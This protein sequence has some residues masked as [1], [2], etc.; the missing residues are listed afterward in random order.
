[1][2][3]SLHCCWVAGRASA[4]YKT[5]CWY[6]D[7][8]RGDPT[9]TRHKWFAHVPVISGCQDTGVP[10]T[11][12]AEQCAKQ[13][14]SIK[15]DAPCPVTVQ[16]SF[17]GETADQR[18]CINLWKNQGCVRPV[19][20]AKGQCGLQRFQAERMP[21]CWHTF[22]RSQQSTTGIPTRHRPFGRSDMPEVS[23]RPAYLRTL[24]LWVS[25]T[26]SYAATSLWVYTCISEPALSRT[27]QVRHA[28]KEVSE[29]PLAWMP[30]HNNNNLYNQLCH[31][32]LQ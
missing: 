7:A 24:A 18:H 25:C 10:G 9:G 1:M 23:R 2:F 29:A 31:L 3:S 30:V 26:D 21:S 5:E 15:D 32:M 11:E 4:V 22:A 20:Q 14:V 28:G 17:S 19:Q 27:S 16:C 6:A 8:V 13:A 12:L